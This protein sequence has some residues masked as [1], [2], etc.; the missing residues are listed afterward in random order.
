M[1]NTKTKSLDSAFMTNPVIRRLK[2]VVAK[3]QSSTNAT[4]AGVI[5]KTVFFMILTAVGIVLYYSLQQMLT[6]S[7]SVIF[8]SDPEGV[9]EVSLTTHSGMVL[10]AASVIVIVA[11][12]LSTFIPSIVPVTGTLYVLAEGYILAFISDSL[13]PEYRWMSFTAL[14]LTI[15]LVFTLLLLYC[16]K[17]I[18]ISQ[19]FR[20]VISAVFITLIIGS[21]LTFIL[22]F[23]PGL[24][25]ISQAIST[26]MDNPVISIGLSV[27]FV[28]I[29]CLFLIS[30]FDAVHELVSNQMPKKYEWSCAFGIAYTVLYLYLKI[31][32]LLIEIFGK[33][34]NS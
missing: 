12:L 19:K 33:K 15:I 11:A 5:S 34:S 24:S 4:Y 29:A 21:A 6:R 27:F 1:E 14:M 10:I 17:K 32:Q 8:T 25:N 20:T 16:S 22:H 30:D 3:E 23:I 18:K 28:I 2:N 13:K 7:G 26:I 31:L 9:M